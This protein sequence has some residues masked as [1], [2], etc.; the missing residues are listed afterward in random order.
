MVHPS[1]RPQVRGRRPV[2]PPAGSWWRATSYEIH[3][4]AEGLAFIRPTPGAKVEPYNPWDAFRKALE[5]RGRVL[6]PYHE[7]LRLAEG[8]NWRP[9]RSGRGFVVD[10]L[11]T[12]ELEPGSE[13]ELLAWCS[14]HGLLGLLL[15]RVESVTL[16]YQWRLAPA[17]HRLAAVWTRDGVWPVR[18]CYVRINNEWAE[19]EVYLNA[20]WFESPGRDG[21]LIPDDKVPNFLPRRGV[22]IRGPLGL[23]QRRSAETY[24][25]QQTHHHEPFAKTWDRYF[26]RLPDPQLARAIP[27]DSRSSYP[28][29]SP[30]HPGFW[31]LYAEPVGDFLAAAIAF[32]DALAGI[33]AVFRKSRITLNEANRLF[34]E[35][36]RLNDF[37][38]GAA[39]VLDPAGPRRL[40]QRWAAP[41]LIGAYAIMALEDLINPG[42][43]SFRCGACNRLIIGAKRNAAYCSDTCKN[44]AKVRRQRAR[45][46]PRP[47]HQGRRR[48]APRHRSSR[49]PAR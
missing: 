40:E 29:P 3:R 35:S 28:Y 4:A 17:D 18:A 33:E 38:F 24:E 26:T 23:T 41:S 8:T 13:E 7:L 20:G 36:G 6:S 10:G 2:V 14:K 16:A 15:H 47:P 5:S 45:K 21:E 43:R 34:E 39:P 12:Y 27:S 42:K 25:E 32:N 30:A 31:N 44:T 22:S 11:G 37:L 48:G 49:T 46:K 19:K 1:V 9:A